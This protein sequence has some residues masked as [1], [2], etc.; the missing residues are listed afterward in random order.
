MFITKGI[1]RRTFLKSAGCSGAARSR[2]HLLPATS[3]HCA[4]A[5]SGDACRGF[6]RGT[7]SRTACR[8]DTAGAVRGRPAH[9]AALHSRSQLRRK[10]KDRTLV[11][12]ERGSGR[13]RPWSCPRGTT[14]SDHWVAAAAAPGRD[15][16]VRETCRL[17]CM[18]WKSEATTISISS[19]CLQKI[20][21][22]TR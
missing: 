19:S 2:R 12:H 5:A 8:P 3:V 9:E 6:S 18:T 14:G 11:S 7:S 21:L 20:G 4:A 10:V 1:P 17:G 16:A 22:R 13:S 15:R